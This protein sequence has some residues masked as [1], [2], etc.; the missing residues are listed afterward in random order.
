MSCLLRG[1]QTF[2]K[3]KSAAV[4]GDVMFEREACLLGLHA[5]VVN[6]LCSSIDLSNCAPVA[7]GG[8]DRPA[9]AT[10]R[11]AAHPTAVQEGKTAKHLAFGDVVPGAKRLPDAIREPFIVCHG[12]QLLTIRH[13]LAVMARVEFHEAHVVLYEHGA[14]DGRS[15]LLAV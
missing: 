8:N 1:G 14:E 3:C 4:L 12:F 11:S 6:R 10:L 5:R 7:G 2:P 15:H 13:L 9:R